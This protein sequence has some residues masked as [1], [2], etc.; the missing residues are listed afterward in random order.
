MLKLS[1]RN[2]ELISRGLKT[3][4]HNNPLDP[5]FFIEESLYANEANEIKSFIQWLYE[6]QRGYSMQCSEQRWIEFKRGDQAP[7]HYFN[8]FTACEYDTWNLKTN[9]F[10]EGGRIKEGAPFRIGQPNMEGIFE[11]IKK[12]GHNPLP[13]NIGIIRSMTIRNEKD[14]I[15]KQLTKEEIELA[16]FHRST[17][18]NN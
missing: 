7:K 13:S 16:V 10:D 6:T 2:Q 1:K 8:L 15:V 18:N 12:Y 11:A 17:S 9:K 5:Y 3:V 4:G 14:Q